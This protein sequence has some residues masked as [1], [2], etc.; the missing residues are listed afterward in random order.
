MVLRSQVILLRAPH[1]IQSHGVSCTVCVLSH[2]CGPQCQHPSC[3][4][5]THSCAPQWQRACLSHSLG[6]D[7]IPFVYSSA[8]KIVSLESTSRSES[9][10]KR[11]QQGPDM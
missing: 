2:I 7:T 3:V 8:Q 10:P 9:G 4:L 11:I 5:A 6:W 1:C